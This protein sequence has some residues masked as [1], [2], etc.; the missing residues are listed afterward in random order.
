MQD[1]DVPQA[2]G[3]MPAAGTI[4]ELLVGFILLLAFFNGLFTVRQ[5]TVAVIERF[6]SFLRLA[7]PG[8]R[9]KIPFVDRIAGRQSLRIQQLVVPVETITKDKVTISIKVAVQFFIQAEKVYDAFYRLTD[10]AQ[11]ITSYVFDV[12]R[13]KVPTIDLDEVFEKK[14]EI[15]GAV[16]QE[17]TATLD[18]FGYNIVKALVTEIDPDKKVKAAMN[19]INAAQREQAAAKARGEADKI[20]KVKAA[21]AESESKKLQGTGVANQMIEIAKGRKQALDELRQAMPDASAQDL[22]SFVVLT[23]HYDTVREV[24][25]K[26]NTNVLLL[27]YGPNGVTDLGTQLREMTALGHTMGP[28][29]AT[30]GAG[31]ENKSLNGAAH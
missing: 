6:G 27:P 25:A 31:K 1:L 9:W 10:P 20:I 24:G 23:Q 8:L 16:Q 18:Q 15:A 14:D 5:Q 19:D 2:A 12:V 28:A 3:F 26:S 17:L 22:V 11:Q 4:L 13:A 29:A 21:E 7:K 30:P